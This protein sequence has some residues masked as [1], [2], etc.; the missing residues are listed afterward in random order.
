MTTT[1]AKIAFSASLA[2][3]APAAA[4]YADFCDE[5]WFSRDLVFDE[6]GQCFETPL[7]QAIFDNAGCTG[8]AQLTRAETL[9]VQ[10]I[11]QHEADLGCDIDTD[12]SRMPGLQSLSYYRD[13]DLVPPRSPYESA[14][15]GYLGQP[16]SLRRGPDPL[17]A[18]N[19]TAEP[20]DDVAFAHD[21]VLGWQ[22]FLVTKPD[23]ATRGGWVYG[24]FPT[25]CEF[26]AG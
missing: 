6:A 16:F 18:V 5:L 11:A 1:T 13:L 4:Q 7:A 14:C 12:R 10:M 26:A 23:G 2:L 21:P 19:I 17:A 3:S 25:E 15:I 24:D 9:V 8:R 20:G 22:F